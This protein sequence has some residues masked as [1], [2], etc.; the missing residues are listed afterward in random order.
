MKKR[1]GLGQINILFAVNVDMGEVR[2]REGERERARQR[3]GRAGER[4][5]EREKGR[6]KQREKER[7]RK[8]ERE[9]VH[10]NPGRL[11][12]LTFES[13]PGLQEVLAVSLRPHLL[14][15]IF[16]EEVPCPPQAQPIKK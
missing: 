4:D 7:E 8:R 11:G 2:E 16:T 10:L 12:S 9:H 3:K 15:R 14:H 5:R 13:Q 6:V 1:K